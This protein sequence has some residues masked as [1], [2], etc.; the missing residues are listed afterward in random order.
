MDLASILDKEAQAWAELIAKKA[1]TPFVWLGLRY[2][3]TLEFW[4]WVED[5]GLDYNRWAPNE[6]TEGCNISVAMETKDNY[7]WF[8]KSDNEKF[9]FIC[10]KQEK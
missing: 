9:N 4:F 8:S 10:A 2:T 7:L 5:R 1:E 6:K 3:C